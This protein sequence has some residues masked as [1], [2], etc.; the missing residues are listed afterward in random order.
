MSRR[1]GFADS[2]SARGAAI[3]PRHFRSRSALVHKHQPLWLDPLHRLPPRLA[4][5]PVFRRVLLL[6]VER[7]FLSRSSICPSTPH[8]RVRPSFTPHGSCICPC[9]SLKVRSGCARSN[10]RNRSWTS[11]VTRLIR[12]CRCSLRSLRPVRRSAA[13]I[14]F[15]YP[16]AHTE[17]PG[18][19]CQRPLA[20]FM[21]LQKL[22]PQIVRVSS[23]HRFVSENRQ[24]H[25]LH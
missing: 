16:K 23:C 25:S 21:R 18:Q 24:I 8:S 3:P 12:P 11:G 4:A 1:G 20:L 17:S 6:R 9:H 13:E 7:F 15:A 14:F 22:P 10:P 2:F 5:L 19:L